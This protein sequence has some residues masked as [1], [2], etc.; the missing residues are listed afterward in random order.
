MATYSL[1][2]A[3]AR[4]SVA[5]RIIYTPIA[6]RWVIA[7]R[8]GEEWIVCVVR[9]PRSGIRISGIS[10]SREAIATMYQWIMR[11]RMGE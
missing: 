9:L 5:P 10:Y 7:D 2:Q 3:I 6:G 4:A 8:I 11:E 1:D